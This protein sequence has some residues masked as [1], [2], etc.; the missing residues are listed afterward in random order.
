MTYLPRPAPSASLA[1]N[2]QAG[3]YTLALSDAESIVDMTSPASV[4]LT[5]P[6][7]ATVAFPVNTVIQVYQI[8]SG[9]ITVAPAA[10]VAL[11]TPSTVTSRAQYSSLLLRKHGA[12]E[13]LLSGDLT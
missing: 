12:D 6:A 8:G 3:P 7:S 4:V 13:W 11:L 1:S 10:G 9:Q 5:I 2:T